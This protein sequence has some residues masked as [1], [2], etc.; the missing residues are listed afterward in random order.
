[1]HLAD[2]ERATN[3]A[4]AFSL[5][6]IGDLHSDRKEF[7]E[8]RYLRWRAQIIKDPDAV[9]VF[10][11]DAMEGRTPG[12]KHFDVATTRPDF[13]NNLD[14]Y[15]KHS[16]AFNERLLKPITD[17]GVPLVIVE[18]NHD[19]YQEYSGYAAM[20][21]DRTG[22]HFL[23]G[24]GFI[25]VRTRGTGGPQG[26]TGAY[27]TVIH[28]SHGTGGGKLPGSKINAMQQQMVWLDA[29]VIIAGHVHD[30]AIRVIHRMGVA[31]R[32][33]MTLTKRPVAQYRA[34]SFVERSIP[35][36][37]SYAGRK[38]YP[39]SDE[40]LQWLRINPAE[41]TMQRHEL[42]VPPDLAWSA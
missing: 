5:Y 13:L 20:L 24:E 15:I 6:A 41:Q 18:G 39:T 30:G 23:G 4:G 29:D 17:A 36:L 28:A 10:V 37:V 9:C 2:I 22:A 8:K 11:G 19:R 12:M 34:P 32:G 35:G 42:M 33:S 3:S 27:T 40:G 31:R 21:A 38:G 7:V 16:L 26:K 1:M 14:S 25:R